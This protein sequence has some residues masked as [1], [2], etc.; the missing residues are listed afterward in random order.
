VKYRIVSG[1]LRADAARAGAALI[2]QALG[3]RVDQLWKRV[4]RQLRL[5]APRNQEGLSRHVLDD[6]G[7]GP[8][9]QVPAHRAVMGAVQGTKALGVALVRHTS[10]VCG[11]G[12]S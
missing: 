10:T 8:G 6:V 5:A 7:V 12:I 9:R 4:I 1:A 2:G 11:H 3:G